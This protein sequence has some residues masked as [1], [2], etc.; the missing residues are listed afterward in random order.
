MEKNNKSSIL[1]Y[2]SVVAIISILLGGIAY[3]L[4]EVKYKSEPTNEKASTKEENTNISPNEP[5]EYVIKN[6]D[7]NIGKDLNEDIRE[8]FKQKSLNM[9]DLLQKEQGFFR[10]YSA[11]VSTL[12]SYDVSNLEN[13]KVVYELSDELLNNMYQNFK[14]EFSEDKFKKITK[15][16]KKWIDNKKKVE[17]EFKNDELVKYQKFINMTLDKCEEWAN[18]YK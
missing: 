15:T 11:L 17:K 10:Y 2:V 6:K 3:L 8:D 1:K 16:Q 7:M 4:I 14:T 12:K 18:Y 13:A 5:N 9:Q